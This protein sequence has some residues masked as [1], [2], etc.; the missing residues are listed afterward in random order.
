M[1][2]ILL[3]A[4]AALL[5]TAPLTAQYKA[6]LAQMPV[7]AESAEKG[8]LVDL[9]KAIAAESGKTIDYQVVPFARSMDNVI[10]GRVDFHMPLIQNP[11]I[12]EAELNYDHST[13]TIFH[14]NFV[15]YYHKDKPLDRNNLSNYVIETD[16]AHVRY[17]PFSAAASTNLESSLRKLD[18]KRIDGFV[19]ADFASDPIVKAHNLNNI[20]REL[21]QVFEVKIILPKGKKGGEADTFLSAIIA[22]MRES[23]DYQAIMNAIDVEY[24]DWQP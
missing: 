14:V 4:A 23:G 22:R 7:Y 15:L 6:S 10:Q 21:Y 2:K 16:A 8:I 3:T 11:L 19:F 20:R 18:M 12:P 1:K 5:C 9:V 24:S 13:A 17:F